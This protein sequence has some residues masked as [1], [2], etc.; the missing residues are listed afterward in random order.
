MS[1]FDQ[2]A[3]EIEQT[4]NG[5]EKAKGFL[6]CQECNVTYPNSFETIPRQCPHCQAWAMQWPG[7]DEAQSQYRALRAKGAAAA[8]RAEAERKV[9]DAP[10]QAPAPKTTKTRV[11]VT[12]EKAPEPKVETPAATEPETKSETETGADEV[13]IDHKAIRAERTAKFIR[14][15]KLNTLT[16]TPVGTATVQ[17]V[18][19]TVWQNRVPAYRFMQPFETTADFRQAYDEAR[20][21]QPSA[22]IDVVSCGQVSD[23]ELEACLWGGDLIAS[24]N[25][26]H[27]TAWAK[28]GDKVEIGAVCTDKG[29]LRFYV[30]KVN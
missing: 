20:A 18:G 26:G 4:V 24:L 25:N 27:G 3:N 29:Y 15:H 30:M 14:D 9:P 11:R 6:T 16:P 8:D 23:P 12:A 28:R 1:I 5:G 2:I 22:R 19:F 21:V 7:D 17:T 10:A 13:E